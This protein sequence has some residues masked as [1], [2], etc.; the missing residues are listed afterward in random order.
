M[1]RPPTSTTERSDVRDFRQTVRTFVDREV[2]PRQQLWESEREIGREVWLAAG[3]Q[4][5]IGLAIPEEFGGLG[6][7]DYR[8]R[9][10]IIEE[11]CRVGA[12]SFT[13][14][15]NLQDDIVVPYILD[16]ATSEQKK[17]WLPGCHSA[18]LLGALALTEP[19]AGSDLQG[20]ASVAVRDGDD[21][22]IRGS[23][24]F[25]TSG[26][27]SDFV[28]V[29]VRTDPEAGSHGFTLMVV[30]NGAPGF[31]RGRKLDKIGLHAQ[32]TAE[33]FFDD[34]RVPSSNILG[35]V[36]GG[37]GHVLERLA[38]ERLS[39]AAFA[40]ASTRA[41]LDWT[42]DYAKQ[43]L[44]FGRRLADF[45]NTQ[46]VLAEI[47]T[48]LEIAEVYLDHATELL[49]DGRL[50]AVAAAK[51]KLWTSELQKRSIDR[52]LQLFGGYGYMTESPIARA[53]LDARV[54]TIYGGS[55][56]IMKV[57]IARDLL[58]E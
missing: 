16:L 42:V 57:I 49:N 58:A 52:C 25:V 54:Q 56:E 12:N 50:T 24:T 39:I 47:A 30:E 14:G 19:S 46:F 17:R 38:R 35:T 32:D 13:A 1:T 41:A 22:L 40:V 9:R 45:Q 18:D 53:F 36:G 2:V 26:M 55:S 44:A 10:V 43:R 6:L 3:K 23:K 51:A 29:L 4:G 28:I 15:I 33:L 7:T 21:W 8:Y 48:E 11:L 34:V 20:I 31:A 5:L 37:L 27:Y